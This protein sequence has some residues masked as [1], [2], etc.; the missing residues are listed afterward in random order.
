MRLRLLAVQLPVLLLAPVHAQPLSAQ[1]RV[2]PIIVAPVVEEY[3]VEPLVPSGPGA[4]IARDYRSGRMRV[5]TIRPRQSTDPVQPGPKDVQKPRQAPPAQQAPEE[6]TAART[7]PGTG[8]VPQNIRIK[9]RTRGRLIEDAGGQRW[10][11]VYGL[12]VD[13]GVAEVSGWLLRGERG[14]P[15]FWTRTGQL[16]KLMQEVR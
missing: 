14:V 12:P 2:P 7:E 11:L 13:E 4:V 1:R 15:H 6:K 9:Q 10:I 3:V 8:A 16:F 5:T